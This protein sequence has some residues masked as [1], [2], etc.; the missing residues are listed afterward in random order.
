MF[1]ATL[2]V[3]Q[4]SGTEESLR[5]AGSIQRLHVV[6]VCYVFV[7][8]GVILLGWSWLRLVGAVTSIAMLI[9][10]DNA[11]TISRNK[12]F[13]TYLRKTK[14]DELCKAIN[15]NFNDCTTRTA[16]YD[17]QIKDFQIQ[18]QLSQKRE[19]N[20]EAIIYSIRDAGRGD[21]IQYS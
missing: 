3:G 5:H 8:V 14:I 9:K 1:I 21:Y 4:N 10:H 12:S 13:F 2:A 7:A 15:E 11:N 18:I 6:P 17:K 19:K 16:D 20:A